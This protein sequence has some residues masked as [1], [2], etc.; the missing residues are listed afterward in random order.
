MATKSGVVQEKDIRNG[1]TFWMPVK[2][3]FGKIAVAKVRVHGR[4]YG[5]EPPVYRPGSSNKSFSAK[6]SYNINGIP[7]EY[8]EVLWLTRQGTA[9]LTYTKRRQLERHIK[10]SS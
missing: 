7:V 5:N 9:R 3:D 6:I 10:L 1:K 8:N 4:V 2:L